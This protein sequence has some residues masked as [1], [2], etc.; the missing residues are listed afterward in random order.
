MPVFQLQEELAFPHPGLANTDGLLAIGGDLSPERLILSYGSGIFPWFSE[1][2]PILW[3]SPDPRFLLFPGTVRVSKSMRK[4]LKKGIF[5]VTLDTC[6]KQ[7]ITLCAHLRPE[8]TWITEEMIAAYSE[9]HALG[10]AH[11]VEVW[12][13]DRL[14]GGLYGVSL[15]SCFFG[16]S[17][18][19]LMDNA[20]K[21]ALITLSGILEGKGFSLIDCQLHT[22]HL[23]T[24]GG[25]DVPRNEF[26]RLLEIGLKNT[27]F[28]GKWTDW[29]GE[30]NN[31]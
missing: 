17:M 18:F 4:V 30:W 3:W 25:V 5:T 8:G 28:R 24:L 19:S 2:D 10:F 12:H 21:V 11:S 29:V 14:V 1:G 13:E 9:V 20:S 31:I 23:E 27:T 6:F 16:E 22:Q 26:L 15:G 7:V